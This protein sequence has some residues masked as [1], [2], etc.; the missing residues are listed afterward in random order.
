MT[1]EPSNPVVII[2]GEVW[3]PSSIETAQYD[4]IHCIAGAILAGA[5]TVEY[6]RIR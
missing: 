1:D 6:K 2:D 4:A 3:K 5:D